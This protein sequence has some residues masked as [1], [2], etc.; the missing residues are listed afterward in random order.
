MKIGRNDPCPCGSGKKYK[1]CCIGKANDGEREWHGTKGELTYTLKER[2]LILLGTA[3]D[4]FG[5]TKGVTWEQLKRNISSE[6]IRELYSVIADIWPPDADLIKLLPEP[7][8]KLRALYLGDVKPELIMRNVFRFGLYADEIFIVDPFHN[9]WCIAEQYN[10]L[11]NPDQYKADTLKLLFFLFL[12]EPWIRANLVTLIPDPGN[13]DYSL[14][15]KTWELAEK[16]YENWQ[17]SSEDITE[18]EPAMKEEFARSLWTTPKDYLEKS[19]RK[20]NPGI[21]EQELVDMMKYIDRLRKDDPLALEQ[22]IQETG[23]QMIVGRTGANLEMA[24]YIAHLTGAFPYTN[25]RRRWEELL[26][27]KEELSESA[28]VWSPITK[29]FQDLDFKFLDNVDSR[30]AC[31][32]RTDGRLESFRAFLRRLWNTVRGEL[33]AGMIDSLARDFRDE[34]TSEHHKAEAEWA[35][36]DSALLKSAGTTAAGANISGG[37][38]L[39]IPALG[40]SIVAVVELIRSRIKRRN[41]RKKIPLSMFVDLSRYKGINK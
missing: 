32:I 40:F 23:G 29:A 33:D 37:L 30:F 12:L 6:Q 7:D 4:I 14:R 2:N 8:S 27:A 22:P 19:F 18:F 36:I 3:A 38:N 35:E 17:P 21:S 10:P 39:E 24:L 26:S 16:R 1:K 41:F 15:R 34:L 5:F 31:S 20:L 28:K 9:P 25:I 11:V 13:F